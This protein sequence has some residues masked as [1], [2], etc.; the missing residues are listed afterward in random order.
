MDKWIGV[1]ADINPN[2]Y[3]LGQAMAN[4]PNVKM[5]VVLTV[6]NEVI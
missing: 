4:N 6:G 5:S 1:S 2:D 3:E